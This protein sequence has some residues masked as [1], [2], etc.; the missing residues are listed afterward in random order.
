MHPMQPGDVVETFASSDLLE[1]LTGYRPET[2]LVKG[3]TEFIRWYREYYPA[4]TE[5]A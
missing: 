3:V 4:A 5:P 2:T 1:L